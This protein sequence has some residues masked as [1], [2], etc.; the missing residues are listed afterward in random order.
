MV[1]LGALLKILFEPRRFLAWHL[2]DLFAPGLAD[3]DMTHRFNQG[4]LTL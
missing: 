3:P 1:S 2:F 4:V